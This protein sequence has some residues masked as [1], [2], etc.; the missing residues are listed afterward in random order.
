MVIRAE[1]PEYPIFR[2]GW[3]LGKGS[4][5]RTGHF[6][7]CTKTALSFLLTYLE[8]SASSHNVIKFIIK[9]HLCEIQFRMS[10]S[11]FV[12]QISYP[13]WVTLTTCSIC[14]PRTTQAEDCQGTKSACTGEHLLYAKV[15]AQIMLPWAKRLC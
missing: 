7:A 8:V 12:G 13:T 9:L 15:G 5:E 1:L 2:R 14:L 11:D 6:F 10:S 4:E 3:K